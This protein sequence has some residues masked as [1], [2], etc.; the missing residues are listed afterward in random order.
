MKFA[1]VATALLALAGSAVAARMDIVEGNPSSPLK[2]F[3]YD[4]L[5]CSDC[6]TF[7]IMLDE[8]ILPKYGSR[9]A[10]VHRDFPLGKHDWARQAALAGRWVYEQNQ[11]D[12]I[13]FRREILAEQNNI[14]AQN[15]KSWLQEFARRN[16]LDQKGIISAL[17]DARLNSLVD[18]DRQGGLARGVK[19]TPTVFVGGVSFAE[20][21][22]YEDLAR[23]IDE[24]LAQ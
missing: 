15:L 5:Q 24:A 7:R 2:V 17:D 22:I 18:Q 9:V 3:I 14:N 10:F 23:A 8:K 13:T 6:A 1:V 16:Q 12:G 19:A 4:D 21:I 20:T 11:P